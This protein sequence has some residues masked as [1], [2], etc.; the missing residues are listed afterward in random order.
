MLPVIKAMI[1]KAKNVYQQV[2]YK[3]LS[4]WLRL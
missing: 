2:R 1:L 3:C 4:I